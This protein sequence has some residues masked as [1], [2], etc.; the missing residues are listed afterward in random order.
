M[1]ELSGTAPECV[2]PIYHDDLSPYPDYRHFFILHEA[3]KF[4]NY[5]LKLYVVR[6]LSREQLYGSRL[7]KTE[8][9]TARQAKMKR[10]F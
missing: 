10:F 7:L 9:Q 3:K 1:V 4:C 2:P 6:L 5:C 8:I